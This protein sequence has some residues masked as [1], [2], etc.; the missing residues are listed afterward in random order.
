MRGHVIRALTF[1]GFALAVFGSLWFLGQYDVP[2]W[3][4]LGAIFVLMVIWKLVDDRLG[5]S[6][7][8]GE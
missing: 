7:G 4:D 5:V 3:Y 8:R 2:G 6:R 1:T